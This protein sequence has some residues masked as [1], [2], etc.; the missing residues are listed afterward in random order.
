M[1]LEEKAIAYDLASKIEYD[2]C[3]KFTIASNRYGRARGKKNQ[4]LS[5]QY[6]NNASACWQRYGEALVKRNMA[7][8][9]YE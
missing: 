9:G 5:R 6:R 2:R 1:G 4:I 3:I 7:L 8:L